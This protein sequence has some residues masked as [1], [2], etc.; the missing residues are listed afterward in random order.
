[1]R[2]GMITIVPI[3]DVDESLLKS[4][5]I[6]LEEIFGKKARTAD[7]I[8]P[9]EESWHRDRT[10]YL[11]S[12]IFAVLPAPSSSVDRVLGVVDVDLFARGLNFVFGQADV[13]GRRAVIS[14]YRLRQEFYGFAHNEDIFRQRTLKEA[15]HELGHT[16]GIGHCPNPICVMHFSNTL[17]DTDLKGWKFC[18]KCQMKISREM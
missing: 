1:M 13:G 9:P 3:G 4:L 18:S 8:Q 10:Q 12:A 14:L 6:S 5:G 7:K 15:V 11:A 16:Y 17:S 2:S